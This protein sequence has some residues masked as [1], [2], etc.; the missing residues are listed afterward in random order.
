VATPEFRWSFAT[1]FAFRFVCA[2][3]LSADALE[4]APARPL[5]GNPSADRKAR[6]AGMI[7]AV[8]IALAILHDTRTGLAARTTNA[9]SSP[10]YGIWDVTETRRDGVVVP[11]VWSDPGLW[12]RLVVQSSNTA[13]IFPL[14]DTAPYQ[15]GGRSAAIRYSLALDGSAR[16][17]ELKPFPF[18]GAAKP[19]RFAYDSPDAN[20]LTLTGEDDD[21]RA[22][23]LSLRR[24]H[25]AD[26]PLL[27]WRRTWR[28]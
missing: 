8:W 28:W 20:Q 25:P 22:I 24:Y 14:S 1:L 11:M 2:A 15:A 10:L 27:S 23:A 16:T 13:M 26:Y 18:F 21:G 9:E 3:L 17:L 6:I 19:R 4:A 12:R 5:F 7:A